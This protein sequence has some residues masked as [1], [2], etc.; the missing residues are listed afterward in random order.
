MLSQHFDDKHS[1]IYDENQ[2]LFDGTDRVYQR[3][4]IDDRDHRLVITKLGR[5]HNNS[6]LAKNNTSIISRLNSEYDLQETIRSNF[7]IRNY[8]MNILG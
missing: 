4:P 7:V 5:S 2:E 3:F 1:G 6:Y 8:K